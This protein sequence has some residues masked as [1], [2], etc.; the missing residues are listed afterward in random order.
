MEIKSSKFPKAS[1][2][3]NFHKENRKWILNQ[4]GGP[5]LDGKRVMISLV[6]VRPLNSLEF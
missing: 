3:E 5:V 2:S 6:G 4:I 1:R